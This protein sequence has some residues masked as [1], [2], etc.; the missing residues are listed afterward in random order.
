M[1]DLVKRLRELTGAG[2]MEC[3]RALE[4]ADADFEKAKAVLS[5]RGLAKAEKKA[6]RETGIGILQTYIHNNRIGVLLE[7]RCETDFVARTAD[8]RELSYAIAQQI[9]AMNPATVDELLQQHFIRDESKYMSAVIKGVIA[10]V[11]ENI[12]VSRF[13]RYEV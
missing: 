12:R 5:A 8:V 7:I 4:E 2:V 1:N 11:G 9:A 13:T 3:K 10:K 6:D